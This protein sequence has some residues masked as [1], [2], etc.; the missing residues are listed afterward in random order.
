MTDVELDELEPGRTSVDHGITSRV[1]RSD[2]WRSM[3]RHAQLDT[4]RGRALQS[5]SNVFLHLY[6]VKI[7]KR[8]LR[9]ALLVPARLHRDGAVRDPARHRR[10]PDVRVHAVGQ[11]R[12]RRHAAA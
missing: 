11:L 7:P 8:V 12:L 2:A 5:F 3:F 9:T 6:P 10:V 1:K 4:P